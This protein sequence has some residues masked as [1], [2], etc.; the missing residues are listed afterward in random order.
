M[1]QRLRN[2]RTQAKSGLPA[3]IFNLTAL[4]VGEGNYMKN[5]C[6]IIPIMTVCLGMQ[7]SVD[8]ADISQPFAHQ[9]LQNQAKEIA[10]WKAD[11]ESLP[12]IQVE[13]A[14]GEKDISSGS[15]PS[16]A[17]YVQEIV[18]K[19]V[20]EELDFLNEL[21]SPYENRN[22]NLSDIEEL[23]QR[24]NKKLQDKG[25]VTSQVVIPEQNLSKKELIL[26]CIPGKLRHVVYAQGSE[27]LP[28]KN[29]FPIREGDLLNLRMLEEGL[30]NMKRVPSFDVSMKILPTN[31]PGFSDLELTIHSQKQVHGSLS[32]DDSGMKETGK[33]QFTTSLGF[34]RVFNANDILYISNTLDTSREW[35]E[36]G[37]RSQSFSYSIP[38]GKDRLTI[39]HS[40]NRYNQLVSSKP[41]DFTS[42][43]KS[44]T[45]RVSLEHMISRSQT[46]RRSVDITVSKRDSHYFIND[47]EIPVQAMD[48][49]ALEIGFNDRIYFGRNTL[50]LRA[51]HKQGMGWFGAQKENEYPDAPKTRYQMWLFDVD[52]YQPFTMGHRPATFSSSLHGQWNTK[53]NRLYGV[54]MLS[55]GNRYTVN[56]FDGEYTLMG[57][58]GWY[59]RNELASTIPSLHSEAYV[60]LDVGFVYGVSTDTLVGKTIAGTAIG[61]RGTFS[62]GLSYDAFI[63]RALYKPEGYHTKRWP[64]GF[65]ITCKF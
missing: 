8:A 42:S 17:F 18:L 47:T 65:T 49:S 10:K 9:E 25:Y 64:M 1:I 37:T 28:W 19:N 46:E 11:R 21:L 32:F 62:S 36:K 38:H 44:Q 33:D 12:R 43:G 59:L 16:A 15:L 63:S 39:S 55:I 60:G 50:Y 6:I 48:T 23:V 14:A 22:L 29:A 24:L 5:R 35:N 41:Y 27:M 56:G 51:A 30:E 61:M 34:D 58:S 3:Q 57:E 7:V 54:D 26:Y 40:R 52:W 2:L 4:H 20:P 45:T 53:G 13:K 31:E